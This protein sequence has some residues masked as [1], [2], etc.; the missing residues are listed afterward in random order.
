[1][2]SPGNITSNVTMG[3]SNNSPLDDGKI[4]EALRWLKERTCWLKKVNLRQRLLRKLGLT[5]PGGQKQR[6]AIARALARKPEILI[7][8]VILNFGL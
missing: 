7:L 1:M 4:W 2:L 3:T 6:L 8:T 5:S